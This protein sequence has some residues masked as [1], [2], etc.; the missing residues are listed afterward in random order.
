MG[1][2]LAA[3]LVV[4]VVLAWIDAPDGHTRAHRLGMP[5]GLMIGA[6]VGM[7]AAAPS[8]FFFGPDAGRA[9]RY[10]GVSAA[11]ALPLLAVA[12]DA[13][14][15]RWR[16]L[17]PVIFAVFLLPLPWSISQMQAGGLKP[18]YYRSLENQIA[19]MPYMPEIKQVP[20]WVQ[21][22][23]QAIISEPGLTVGWLRSAARQGK[24]PPRQVMNPLTRTVTLVQLGLAVRGGTSPPHLTCRTSS[25]P[26]AV[27]PKLGDVWRM[28]TDIQVALR[29]PTG[30]P[31]GFSQALLWS[32]ATPLVQ[33]T[34]PN[35]KLLVT[36]APGA[37]SFR[38]CT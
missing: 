1:W 27:D 36:P 19:S 21:P 18:A 25:E 9:N 17:T 11:M 23:G 6:A 16:V 31:A 34:L 33:V 22:N 20:S 32:V 37:R 30:K 2:V 13:L 15:R 35:L 4:G 38:L 14:V 26:V 12:G 7:A 10:V 5:I 24:L 29:G 28:G 3:T 8:R